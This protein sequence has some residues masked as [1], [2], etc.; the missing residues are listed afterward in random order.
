MYAEFGSLVDVLNKVD[1]VRQGTRA[2][3]TGKNFNFLAGW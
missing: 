3:I 2:V 1:I